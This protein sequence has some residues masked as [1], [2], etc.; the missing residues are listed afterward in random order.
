MEFWETDR[1]RGPVMSRKDREEIM[2]RRAVSRRKRGEDSQIS[3]VGQN[4]TRTEKRKTYEAHRYGDRERK[5]EIQCKH[6][7]PFFSL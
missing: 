4:E 3:R 7:Y 1:K 5:R 6:V 2:D